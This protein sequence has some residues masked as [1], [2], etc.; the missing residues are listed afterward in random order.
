M[1]IK[2]NIK[3]EISAAPGLS[4]PMVPVSLYNGLALNL[5]TNALKAV[6]AKVGSQPGKIAFRAWNE[7]RWH[8]LEVSDT[9]IGIPSA[10]LERVFQP[11][12]TTTQSRNDPLGSGMGLGLTLVRRGAEAFGGR[13]DLVAPAGDFATCVRVRLPL[14]PIEKRGMNNDKPAILLIDDNEANLRKLVDRLSRLLPDATLEDWCP[15]EEEG[16]PETIFEAFDRRTG[17]VSGCH[18]LRSDDWSE[19]SV[20]PQ[21]CRMVSKPLHTRRR[22]FASQHRG[23]SKGAEPFRTTGFPPMRKKG[24]RSL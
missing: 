18:G 22:F 7:G 14:S 24:L 11:L 23:A 21:H 13:T 2:R 19:G 3:V 15:T 9:G 4:A 16:P 1:H 6:T 5:Y 12:F 8:Y 10:L 17:T 20:R